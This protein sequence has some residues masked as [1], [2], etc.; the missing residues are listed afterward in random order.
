M[1]L[2]FSPGGLRLVQRVFVLVLGVFVLVQR[3]FV[4]VQGVFVLAQWVFVLVQGSS[5]YSTGS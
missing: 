3:A 4:L 1:G 2:R 5:F